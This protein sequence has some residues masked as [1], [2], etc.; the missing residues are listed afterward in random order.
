MVFLKSLYEIEGGHIMDLVAVKSKK[1]RPA[2]RRRHRHR[3]LQT[4]TSEEREE[5][6]QRIRGV[7]W[8]ELKRHPETPLT[9]CALHILSIINGA[10]T[11][12]K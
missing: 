1:S 10:D 4:L 8:L 12:G 3:P 7:I 2:H 5:M 6:C 9:R 11:Q